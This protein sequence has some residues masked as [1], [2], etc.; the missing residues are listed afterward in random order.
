MPFKTCARW[1][2]IIAPALLMTLP[3][4]SAV[5]AAWTQRQ[6]TFSISL[7]TTYTF[8]G[9]QL[10]AD[11]NRVDRQHFSMI[12]TGPA[13]GYGVTDY[14]TLGVQPIFRHVRLNAPD[15][16][17]TNTGFPQ[18]ESY[19][20]LR[21]WSEGHQAFS[22]QGWVK[23]PVD[24]RQNSRVPLGR[25]QVDTELRLLYGNRHDVGRGRIFYGGGLAF[26]K[27]FEDP[28][29]E[30]HADAFLGWWPGDRLTMAVSFLNTIG[31]ANEADGVEVLTAE[32]DFRRHRL[33]LN[34]TY[35]VSETVSFNAGATRTI[36]GRRVGLENSVMGGVQVRF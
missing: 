24:P 27:R 36:F 34:A 14:L 16:T 1:S 10:D 22:I 30:V 3:P 15:G 7:P 31:L 4:S 5:D 6:G 20:R 13:F 12:E 26:R 28:S 32:P 33:R 18:V 21:L 25:N 8:I 19:A 9:K 17:Q 2:L 29:D 35:R 23:V 11:G